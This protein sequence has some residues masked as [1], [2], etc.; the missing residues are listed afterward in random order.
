MQ[1]IIKGTLCCSGRSLDGA[2]VDSALSVTSDR[3][4]VVVDGGGGPGG[5]ALR[6][7]NS[8]KSLLKNLHVGKPGPQAFLALRISARGAAVELPGKF[9]R[10]SFIYLREALA[11]SPVRALP[12]GSSM[13]AYNLRAA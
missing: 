13:S 5:G 8:S 6:Q 3:R 12:G 4:V 7:L 1:G 10:K 2:D 9:S 11:A